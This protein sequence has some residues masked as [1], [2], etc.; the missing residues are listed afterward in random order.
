MKLMCTSL[1]ICDRIW[2]NS[3]NHWL[4]GNSHLSTKTLVE[5]KHDLLKDEAHRIGFKFGQWHLRSTYKGNRAIKK[6]FDFLANRSVSPNTA[7]M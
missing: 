6:N 5:K 7:T 2:E 4:R 1:H 3:P